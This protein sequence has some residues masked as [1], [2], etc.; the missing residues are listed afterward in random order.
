VKNPHNLASSISSWTFTAEIRNLNNYYP[1]GMELPGG[2]YA[3]NGNYGYGYNG[4]EK[5][6]ELKG[7][8]KLYSTLFREGDTENGRW[9]SRDPKEWK[10]PSLSPY[11]M[12]NNNPIVYKDLDGREGVPVN[13]DS[14]LQMFF[15]TVDVQ[16]YQWLTF[17]GVPF[18]F[19]QFNEA[20]E[21]NTKTNN[22]DAYVNIQ[23][24]YHYYNWASTQVSGK[25]FK[26]AAIV[27]SRFSVGAADKH[28]WNAFFLTDDTENMLR[29]VNRDLFPFNMANF[30]KIRSDELNMTFVN[31]NKESV[32]FSGLK[33]IELDYALVEFEQTKVQGIL[34][35]YIRENPGEEYSS[36]SWTMNLKMC[37]ADSRI[38]RVLDEHFNTELGQDEFDFLN[39]NHRVK[40]GKELI[41]ILYEEDGTNKSTGTKK[42][43][44]NKNKGGKKKS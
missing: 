33:G 31:Y 34:E 35:K 9:W 8:G 5:D 2:A 14:E 38:N 43:K 24:R 7:S 21:H 40:L 36:A 3:S 26:A 27:N 22:S 11:G 15:S 44:V 39:Y 6:D 18:D 29:K 42:A 37:I 16:E 13:Y 30:K 4:M 28:T 20:A 32:S 12:N 10:Y 1:Y 19:K 23:E 25:W 41:N 17:H